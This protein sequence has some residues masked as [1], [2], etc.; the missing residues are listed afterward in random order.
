MSDPIVTI[1]TLSDQTAITEGRTD[2]NLE[3]LSTGEDFSV[4]N[5][6]VVPNFSDDESVLPHS[7]DVAGL[8]NFHNVEIPTI[9]GR[10]SIDVLIGQT[11]KI[12]L[13]FCT[14][15]RTLIQTNQIMF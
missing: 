6:L 13:P 10:K 11:D 5:A 14:R 15:A 8:D 7:V 3:S 1:K 9:P 2:F 12:C 4:K